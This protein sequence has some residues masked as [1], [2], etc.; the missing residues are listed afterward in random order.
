MQ[1]GKAAAPGLSVCFCYALLTQSHESIR[2]IEDRQ[3]W[4][5]TESAHNSSPFY[6]PW[7]CT[8][9]LR[10]YYNIVSANKTCEQEDT[11]KETLRLRFISFQ[12]LEK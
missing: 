6:E 8:C 1:N 5:H 2:E 12:R 11:Q 7:T 10:H 9:I 4:L 3:N